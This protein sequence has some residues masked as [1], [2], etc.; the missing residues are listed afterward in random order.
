[1][2][3]NST[4]PRLLLLVMLLVIYA[5]PSIAAPKRKEFNLDKL[6]KEWADK[7]EEDD[8]WHEDSFEWKEKERK[9]R[10]QAKMQN[11]LNDGA[12]GAGGMNGLG[13]IGGLGGMASMMGNG[14]SMH[15]SFAELKESALAALEK[16]HKFPTRKKTLDFLGYNWASLLMTNA[17][18]VQ[19]YSIEPKTI[20]FTNNDVDH[21][22]DV[23]KEFVLS[24]PEVEKWT[25]N[26]QD[27][28]PE[29]VKPPTKKSKEEK[30]RNKVPPKG[31]KG[32]KT[33]RKRK[34]RKKKRK[35]SRKK[36][37]STQKKEL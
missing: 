3:N 31:G 11:M 2:L 12:G 16:Q 33:R 18:T 35:M 7:E 36:K 27:F 9:R 37:D 19:V 29:G 4:C 17:M 20:L 26:S 8:D 13:G 32:G 1:M 14:N 30:K 21:R 5:G 23:L 15:M 25:F 10:Q 22:E 34:S 28:Y 24:Q 6:E